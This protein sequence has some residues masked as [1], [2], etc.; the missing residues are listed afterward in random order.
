[1]AREDIVAVIDRFE[2][3]WAVIEY[4]AETFNFPR[5]LLPREA[6]EGDVI[7]FAV[8]VDRFK[9]DLRRAGIKSLEDDL[10]R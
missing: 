1:M 2:E 9:S 7:T 3:K 10:F 8:T 4:G 5:G 6:G